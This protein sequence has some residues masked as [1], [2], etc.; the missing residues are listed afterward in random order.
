MKYFM[1]LFLLFVLSTVC[2]GATYNNPISSTPTFGGMTL[3]GNLTFSSTGRRIFGDFSNS[4]IINR[5]LFQSSTTDG[6]TT[7]TALPNGAA[8]Q[9]G[10][11]FYTTSDPTNA[12]FLGLAVTDGLS[13]NFTSS[14]TG[15]GTFLPIAFTVNAAERMRLFSGSSNG[16][17]IAT[18]IELDS[19]SKLQI[20]G[21]ASLAH[22]IG[23]S[24]TPGIAAGTGAGTSPT[25]SIAGTDLAFKV[26]VT[27]GTLPTAAATVA[28]IT[29][30]S[31]YGAIPH[32]VFS[33]ANSNA[34]ILSGVSMVYLTPSTTTIVINAGATALTAA[35]TYVWEFIVTQ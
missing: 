30:A 13:A 6:S 21:N 14:K 19:T 35:T 1:R 4:T 2:Q 24:T 34:A 20:A 33:S 10:F 9:A 32:P 15:T 29:F 27:T 11:R 5:T 26:T 8:L 22:V 25:V 7:I 18:T 23:N 28:T 3:S 16:L 31:T 17:L 12:S